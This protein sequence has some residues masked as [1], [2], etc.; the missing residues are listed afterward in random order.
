[1]NA[2][3]RLR[4]ALTD[5]ADATRTSPDALSGV[6]SRVAARRRAVRVATAGGAALALV[7]GVA[8]AS[9]LGGGTDALRP[10]RTVP[11]GTE[12]PAPE[13]TP[14]DLPTPVEPTV[15]AS[16]SASPSPTAAGSPS[17][18]QPGPFGD[19][20]AAAVLADG[21]LALLSTT[22]G[23]VV[24]W[25]G[26]PKDM[27]GEPSVDW[28]PATRL[29][30]HDAGDCTIVET[31]LAT[32]ATRV[33]GRG[34]RPAVGPDGRVLAIRCAGGVVLHDPRSGA[35]REY[36][37][38]R[39]VEGSATPEDAYADYTS[40]A[41]DPTPDID[42][43]VVARTYTHPMSLVSLD[44]ASSDEMEAAHHASDVEGELVDYTGGKVVTAT[45]CCRMGQSGR[46][47]TIHRY[48]NLDGDN[49]VQYLHPAPVTHLAQ[50]A[51]GTILVVSA[52]GLWR[53]HGDE[54][55]L[56][57]KDVVAVG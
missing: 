23:D 9:T 22:T 13:P 55:L 47:T 54:R 12:T 27:A 42:F 36:P 28:S 3:E 40:V 20:T 57:R 46:T 48:D 14:S 44:L 53:Y 39:D 1:M 33:V 4:A 51:R 10:T 24:R 15:T 34:R 17:P 32:H 29:V 52:D 8:F 26:R 18:E 21:R 25:L 35:T 37:H 2:E 6:F 5:R 41:W 7:A 45:Y 30:Y 38:R 16:A 11:I 19:D 43:A 49:Q 56:L 50:D 31:N